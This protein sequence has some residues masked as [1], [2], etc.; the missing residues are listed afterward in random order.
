MEAAL[1]AG[2]VLAYVVV[3]AVCWGDAVLPVLPSETTVLAGGVL[4]SQ[5]ALDL[6]PLL[7]MAAA[8]A[9]AG[10]LTAVAAG[11][12]LPERPRERGRL[13]RV[14][15]RILAGT[16]RRVHAGLARHPYVVLL[17][18]R[19]V[20]GGRTAVT[21]SAGRS[22]VP[23]ARLVAPIAAAGLVWAVVVSLVGPRR[24]LLAGRLS[25][26]PWSIRGHWGPHQ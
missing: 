6:G 1:Q 24:W 10:D 17:V 7:A 22:A 5:G 9:V 8:G 25:V 15:G 19:F 4:C 12:R 21:V 11:G 13:S 16:E 20:P 26:D 14:L 23:L 3:L 2:P 18:A